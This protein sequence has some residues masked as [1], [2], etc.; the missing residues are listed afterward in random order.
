MNAIRYDS[1]VI[2]VGEL[3]PEFRAQ[4]VLVFFGEQAP[5][6]LHEF[7][8]LHRP[9]VAWSAPRAGDVVELDGEP[10]TVTAVGHV[11]EQNLLQLGHLDLKANG[12]TQAPLPGDVCVE[13][14]PLP[15]LAPGSRLRI[16]AAG[17]APAPARTGAASTGS[18]TSEAS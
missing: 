2:S 7:C 1:A 18:A 6:E 13:A 12:A 16:I 11:V 8:I 17:A 5:P 9:S 10:F 3:I 14:K 15:E 4:G